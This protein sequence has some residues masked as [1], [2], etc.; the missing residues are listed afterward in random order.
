[1]P[2]NYKTTTNNGVQRRVLVV[3]CWHPLQVESGVAS[4][5]LGTTFNGS[6][7][8]G[9]LWSMLTSTWLR[10]ATHDSARLTAA[11]TTNVWQ[12]VEDDN[13]C[14]NARG[15]ST[16]LRDDVVQDVALL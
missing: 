16:K 8:L 12:L 3:A 2:E 5:F 11:A 15:F 6:Y 13:L 7:L 10:L 14:G 9:W 1:M 4:F